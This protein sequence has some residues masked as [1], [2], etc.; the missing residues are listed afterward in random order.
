MR[1]FVA[2]CALVV[3]LCGPG[4]AQAASAQ[5]EA[6]KALVRSFIESYA[7]VDRAAVL[8]QIDPEAIH[9]YGSDVA[10]FV[11]DRAGLEAM[12][13][14]DGRL[15]GDTASFGAMTNVSI[16]RSRNLATIFFDAPF[17]V[18]GRPPVPVRFA[19]VWRKVGARWLLTQSS[20]VVPTVGASAADLLAKP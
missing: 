6:L 8:A 1:V 17:T 4:V 7:K 15:W 14:N 9:V 2:V 5:D 13:A 18:G 10:E 16:V 3:A 12:L 19:M 11:S 20:N